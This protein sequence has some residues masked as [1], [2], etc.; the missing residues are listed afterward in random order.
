MSLA[1]TF[2]DVGQGDA[3]LIELPGYFGLIDFGKPSAAREV[4]GPAVKEQIAKGNEF[5]F[6]AATHFDADHVGGLPIVLDIREPSYFLLP[7]VGLDLIEQWVRSLLV[8]D[9]SLLASIDRLA[10][11]R[12]HRFKCEAG[13]SVPF[14][15]MV[16]GL[17]CIALSPDCH[18]EDEL[19]A[20]LNGRNPDKSLL[21]RLI[22]MRNKT[23]LAL[24]LGYK[25]SSAILLAEI[26]GDQYPNLW[27]IICSLMKS[28]YQAPCVVKLA[29]HGA[30]DN[31]PPEL[32]TY[33]GRKGSLMSVSAGARYGHP[34][35][36][37]L[38]QVE[39][40]GAIPACTNLG[41][42]CHRLIPLTNRPAD[43]AAWKSLQTDLS[44]PLPGKPKCYGAI[45][46]EL[47]PAGQRR[48]FFKSIQAKCPFGGLN[49]AS[50]VLAST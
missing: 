28:R 4:V 11:A 9:V 23:S 46:V 25:K 8:P 18:V 40:V 24:Y 26:E 14:G 43:L 32:F 2:L 38:A 37:V 31:N 50:A 7:A 15:D 30:K 45:R 49:S 1:L 19:R 12:S 35:V 41:Q 48:V 10:K 36:E 5:L 16:P 3:T 17:E 29:H 33:F 44:K 21:D 22:G 20:A 6:A 39:R 34:D 47:G 27:E 42:G 13:F